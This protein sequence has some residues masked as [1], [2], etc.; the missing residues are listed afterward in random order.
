MAKLKPTS[1]MVETQGPNV[2]L[3]AYLSTGEIAAQY[4]FS[5]SLADQLCENIKAACKEIRK[6][7]P[8]DPRQ[9]PIF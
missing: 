6:R 3:V 5:P 4:Q 7:P 2:L 9:L 8:L 1:L